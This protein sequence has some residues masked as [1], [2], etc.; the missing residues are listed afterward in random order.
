MKVCDPSPLFFRLQPTPSS[1]AAVCATAQK[2][3]NIWSSTLQEDSLTEYLKGCEVNTN[4]SS[5]Y[6]RDIESYDYNLKHRMN[7]ANVLKRRQSHSDDSDSS[8]DRQ[9]S[10]KAKNIN[11]ASRWRRS[12]RQ[13]NPNKRF[14]RDKGDDTSSGDEDIRSPRMILDLNSYNDGDHDEIARDIAN[15][16]AEDKDELLC[17]FPKRLLIVIV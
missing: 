1:S 14:H 17:K 13:R 3:Y 7:G 10:K 2:K 9:I 4:C 12:S 11:D 6:D 16:L 15:K 8:P 5:S